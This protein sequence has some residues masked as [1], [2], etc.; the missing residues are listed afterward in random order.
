MT[1]ALA[2][3][4]EEADKVNAAMDKLFAER[5]YLIHEGTDDRVPL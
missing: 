1:Q 4:D 5:G 3:E 2:E